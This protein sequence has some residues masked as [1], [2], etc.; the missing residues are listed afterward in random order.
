[1]M[2]YFLRFFFFLVPKGKE[3][4][5]QWWHLEKTATLN[6][7][8]WQVPFFN[9]KNLNLQP[10]S[11]ISFRINKVSPFISIYLSFYVYSTGDILVTWKNSHL[12]I[13]S[14]IL[15]QVYLPC[16]LWAKSHDCTDLSDSEAKC[17]YVWHR[18]RLCTTNVKPFQGDNNSMWMFTPSTWPDVSVV[19]PQ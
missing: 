1:M 5:C 18:V 13:R 12:G 14:V 11:I 15:A 3:R 2:G 4:W 16:C 10:V 9:W 17:C 8:S 19:K 6:G 7:M